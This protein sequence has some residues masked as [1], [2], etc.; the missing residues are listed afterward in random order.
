MQLDITKM[1]AKQIKN[2]FG[3]KKA[4]RKATQEMTVRTNLGLM[5][6]EG[7]AG[8]GKAKNKLNEVWINRTMAPKDFHKPQK[9]SPCKSTK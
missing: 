9:A 5:I 2:A 6:N 8:A 7:V 1:T 4:Q 3:N